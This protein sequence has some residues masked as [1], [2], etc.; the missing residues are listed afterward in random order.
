MLPD[1]WWIHSVA[2]DVRSGGMSAERAQAVS[3]V[4]VT[5]GCRRQTDATAGLPSAPKMP[6][7]PGQ[8]RLVPIPDLKP[9]FNYS[10][11]RRQLAD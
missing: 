6:C 11:Q 1:P 2:T 7:V 3:P 10:A 4:W 8:L 5:G 9:Q